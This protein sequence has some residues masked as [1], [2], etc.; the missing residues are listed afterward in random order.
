MYFNI[1]Q[2]TV[3]KTVTRLHRA[4]LWPIESYLVRNTDDSFFLKAS[5]NCFAVS[6]FIFFFI[7]FISH[8]YNVNNMGK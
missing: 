6:F 1:V 8:V 7:Y 3:C 4:S 5:N 2:L